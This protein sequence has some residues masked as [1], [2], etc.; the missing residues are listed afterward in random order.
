MGSAMNS[1]TFRGLLSSLRPSTPYA[2]DGDLAFQVL[3]VVVE[4][5]AVPTWPCDIAD[6]KSLMDDRIYE[7]FAAPRVAEGVTH[8]VVYVFGCTEQG[9]SVTLAVTGFEPWLY[10]ELNQVVT[11]T[12]MDALRNELTKKYGETIKV[13]FVQKKRAYGWVPVSPADSSDVRRFRFA[14]MSFP[15]VTVFRNVVRALDAHNFSLIHDSQ[16]SP[17]MREKKAKTGRC[18]LRS[19]DGMPHI[20]VSEVKIQPSEKFL[21]LCNLQPSAWAVVPAG[22]WT[23]VPSNERATLAQVEATC[24]V[25]ALRPAPITQ[26]APLVVAAVDIEVQSGDF[27]SFPNATNALDEC[28]YIGTTFWVYGDRVPRVRVMQVLEECLPVEDVPNMLVLS[29]GSEYELLSAWRDLIVVFGNPDKVVSYNGTGFDYAYMAERVKFFTKR[30]YTRFWHLSRFLYLRRELDERNLESAAMGQNKICSFPMVGRWQM[31]L[32]QYVKVNYKMSSYK[33]DDVTHHFLGSTGPAGAVSKVVLDFPG[34]VEQTVAAASAALHRLTSELQDAAARAQIEVHAW[35]TACLALMQEAAAA[36]RVPLQ[37]RGDAQV[38]ALDKMIENVLDDEEDVAGAVETAADASERYMHVYRLVERAV[39]QF[40]KGVERLHEQL[41]VAAVER[42]REVVYNEVQPALDA[43]GSDNYKKL[44][45]MYKCGPAHRAQIAKY[46]QVDCDLVL[47]L[48]DRIS[49]VPNTVQMSQVCNTLLSDIANRGQQIKTFNLIARY[50]FND[51]YVMNFREVGW[52]P[53]AEYEGATVLQPKPGYYT[54][55]VS[56]LDF[57]SLYPS[58]MQAFNLCFSSIVLDDEY[59]QM[60]G[61]QY[62]R[63]PIAGKEWVFQ[64]KH[65]GLLPKILAE[66]V[67]AR[68]QCKKEMKKFDKGS[69]DYKLA[70]G[71]QLAL[72]IS[73]NSVYGFCGVLKN[74][75][76]PC[77]PV[78][79]ATTFNGRNLIQQ[80]KSFA[81][82]NYG[83]NVIYGD[84]DSVML[85]FPGVTTVSEAFAVAEEVSERC[86]AMFRD[87]GRDVVK[88]EFEKVYLPYLLIKKKHYA[89][90]KYDAESGAGAPPTLD[91]KGL[92]LVRRDNCQLVRT[93]MREVLY[94]AMRDGN[95]LAAYEAV[96]R[97]VQRLVNREVSIE[98]L[99]ISNFLRSDLKD[100]HH[101]HIQVVKN[102]E[103]RHSFGI[104]R[105]G[106]RV[107]YVILEGKKDSKIYER[108][109]HP[110]YVAEQGLKV[111]REYYLLNQMKKRLEKVLTPLPIPSSAAL[112]DRAL[113][114]I[115][116]QREG[117]QRLDA[118]MG[119]TVTST[120][121][122]D[123]ER[124][125]AVPRAPAQKRGRAEPRGGTSQ[126]TLSAQRTLFGGTASPP[127]KKVAR[128]KLA[129]NPTNQPRQTTLAEI[130][131]M[132]R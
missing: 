64:E 63:Y 115:T 110:K 49:V 119:F 13:E 90:I 46:C 34:W 132:T 118:F 56:T 45:R 16:L 72:K 116:R 93:A 32:F 43:S 6:H 25:S 60:Q 74:G 36:A 22:S 19:L 21:A 40:G 24:V 86:S 28:T 94:S 98:E 30:K 124:E 95:P 125:F 77:M 27:R 11:R 99:E 91:A 53:E 51:G 68:R 65:R 120:Q 33:L 5:D 69:L 8:G 23:A 38:D 113:A 122:G 129:E 105:V 59:K 92:A 9:H 112:F 47:Y 127:V 108:A 66:L 114:E 58:I 14:K 2:A 80:T 39:E 42:F 97:H 102:M 29:Y 121:T 55:P 61:V 89:G 50:C 41:G 62:G 4:S 82:T 54:T 37:V 57:A 109:E 15:S 35:C 26:V 71:K 103:A 83:A 81:E 48:M 70:D 130:M 106:D 1:D 75:M 131:G 84:T 7:Q 85:Q 31:D 12:T 111:D 96:A 128:A 20:D 18:F 104:P 100:D 52:D 126:P 117:N 10:V 123:G 76:F 3:D 79:V 88:L 17:E 73:C 44:F 78:A 67:D 101:P 107:P 87:Q